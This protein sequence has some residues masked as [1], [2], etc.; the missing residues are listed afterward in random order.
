MSDSYPFTVWSGLTTGKHHRGMGAALWEF[1]WLVDKVTREE[2]GRG[3]VLGGKPITCAEIAR[4][5]E[6][7]KRQVLIQLQ[8]LRRGGYIETQRRP[9]GTAIVVLR[10]K[11]RARWPASAE[12]KAAKSRLPDRPVTEQTVGPRPNIS[13]PRTEQNFRSDRNICSPQSEQNFA[14]P[15]SHDMYNDITE[16]GTE[17]KPI[18]NLFQAIDCLPPEE[19]RELELQAIRDMAAQ[20]FSRNFLTE[21][22][23]GYIL[24]QSPASRM[25]HRFYTRMAYEKARKGI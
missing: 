13:S 24:G 7:T 9:A 1:L 20:P 3:L 17:D 4:D 23:N 5:L 19:R 11:K 10:S 21:T 12:R 8:K 22:R 25:V 2:N 15:I 14:S 18:D 6:I 16:D